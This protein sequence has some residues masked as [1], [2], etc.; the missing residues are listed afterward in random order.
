ML[1]HIT[2]DVQFHENDNE[3][4]WGTV[5]DSRFKAPR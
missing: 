4:F 3:T 1:L 2:S 5:M